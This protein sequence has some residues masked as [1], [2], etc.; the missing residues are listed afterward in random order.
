MC[1]LLK[2]NKNRGKTKMVEHS[3]H[4]EGEWNPKPPVVRVY[5]SISN[6]CK[7]RLKRR[8]RISR[9][10][11]SRRGKLYSRKRSNMEKRRR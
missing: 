1:I 7:G 5:T 9:K 8:K 11:E 3:K 6:M 10:L 2:R 4:L